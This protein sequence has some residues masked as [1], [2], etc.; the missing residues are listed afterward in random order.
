MYALDTIIIDE[1]KMQRYETLNDCANTI[2]ILWLP[3]SKV[4]LL[5]KYTYLYM[6]YIY[7]YIYIM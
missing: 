2:V 1:L 7:I 5:L 6:L 4:M 3:N